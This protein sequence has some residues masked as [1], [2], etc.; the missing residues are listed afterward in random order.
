M[1]NNN[2]NMSKTLASKT[3][4]G[5]KVA[6]RQKPSAR[7]R[8]RGSQP[9]R[10]SAK[11]PMGDSRAFG[12]QVAAAR[13]YSTAQSVRAP[14]ITRSARG[15]RIRHS[16]LIQ[17]VNGSVAFTATKIAVNPGLDASFPWLAPQAKQWE[18]YHVHRLEYRFVTRTSTATVGSVLL[19]P[20]YDALDTTPTTEA[21][22]STYQ[23]AV[24]DAAWRDQ[25]CRLSVDAMH[26]LGPRKYVRSAAVGADLKTYDVANLFLCTVEEVGTDAIGKLWVDYDI[27]FFV[28]QSGDSTASSETTTFRTQVAA[29]TLATGVSESVEFDTL[30]VDPL[31]IGTPVVGVFTPPAGAY[32][33]R[34]NVTANDSAT[35]AFSVALQARK[36][37]AN[38][39]VT[40]ISTDN[41]L[42]GGAVN[43]SIDFYVICNGTDTIQINVV[44]TGAAGTLTL[45]AN[46]SQLVVRPA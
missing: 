8:N 25:C 6:G 4:G 45:A 29:Q 11:S 1:N 32:W 13:A 34:A 12:G 14:S 46:Q 35:E 18:Q 5:Q 39:P 37:N 15:M 40:V 24:E 41:S 20:D 17:S 19:A 7:N 28:P 44:A 10:A 22:V 33:V 23:D 2:G 16:E 31:G 30:V 42:G 26:P 27:E 38:L 36:N 21:Q 9:T 3:N 43:V